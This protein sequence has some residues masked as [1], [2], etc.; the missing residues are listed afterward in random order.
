MKRNYFLFH[1][2]NT[3]FFL[4]WFILLTGGNITAQSTT[5]ENISVADSVVYQSQKIVNKEI[6]KFYVTGGAFIVN[7]EIA[8]ADIIKIPEVVS[9]KEVKSIRSKLKKIDRDKLILKK[10]QVIYREPIV[11]NQI[12]FDL[13]NPGSDNFSN[14][15]IFSRSLLLPQNSNGKL[16]AVLEKNIFSL[17]TVSISHSFIKSL[18]ETAFSYS[19]FFKNFQTR[20]PPTLALL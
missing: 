2:Y 13:D 5:I 10:K 12:V 20:P 17:S 8:N 19:A 1:S 14:N 4:F 15:T 16:K 9:K 7:N 11:E 18:L 6:P 3:N